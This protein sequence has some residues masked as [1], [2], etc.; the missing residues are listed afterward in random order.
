MEA[1]RFWDR[2][3]NKY[4]R[5]PVPSEADYQRKLA[6]TREHF[7][8]HS[9]VVEFGCGTGTTAI[10]HAPFVKRL[11]AVDISES[12]LTI[13][14]NQAA[15]AG[16][17][18]VEFV[19]GTLFDLNLADNS[20]DVVMGMSI[21]HLLPNRQETLVEVHRVLKPGGYFI[22]STA[23]VGEKMAWFRYLAPIGQKLGLLPILRV[24][25][26]D[27]LRQDLI[28]SGFNLETDW[29]PDHSPMVLFALATKR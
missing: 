11:R 16:V 10:A 23:C 18:N 17:D 13:A 4:Y 26:M 15:D 7:T 25:D 12:M 29:V 19:G 21:L 8:P 27:D 24:F 14:R 9:E 5:Q 2:I 6:M 28:N 3:A 20:V 1:H 22:S